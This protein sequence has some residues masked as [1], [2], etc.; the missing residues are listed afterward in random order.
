MLPE[1]AT[2]IPPAV[3]AP[4]APD[5][6]EDRIVL[7]DRVVEWIVAV[8]RHMAR[9]EAANVRRIEQQLELM[10][11]QAGS[12]WQNEV[13]LPGY[14]VVA[15]G[16]V[17]DVLALKLAIE[18]LERQVAAGIAMEAHLA[19]ARGHYARARGDNARAR[20]ELERSLALLPP[21][22]GLIRDTAVCALAEALLD[23]GAYEAAARIAAAGAESAR[24]PERLSPGHA[25]RCERTLALAEAA[26]GRPEIAEPR[27]RA[28]LQAA[29]ELGNPAITGSIYEALAQLALKCGDREGF[30]A[31][32]RAVGECFLPTENPVLIGRWRQLSDH[33]ELRGEAG[34]VATAAADRDEAPT[35]AADEGL[36]P[37]ESAG[38]EVP[39]RE[40]PGRTRR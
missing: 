39:T 14:S 21:G 1:L 29:L 18:R 26:L 22:D 34:V 10:F 37:T 28:A 23:S 35:V 5:P 6:G 12:S 30:R 16:F 17:D 13:W 24:A 32:T 19:V 33:A 36:V 3:L 8:S 11:L 40:D 38:P 4:R 2:R 25:I 20:A 31:A 27:L 9:G 7:Q 15:A